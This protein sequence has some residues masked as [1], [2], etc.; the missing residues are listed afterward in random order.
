[1]LTEH[2]FLLRYFDRNENADRL[3][4]INL[5]P[6]VRYCP[7]PEPLLAPPEDR[8]WKLAWSSEEPKYGGGGTAPIQWQEE[9]WILPAHSALLF[10]AKPTNH[11]NTPGPEN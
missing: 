3:L 5:G 6:R 7:A 10:I 11:A 4:L 9:N 8:D 1:V 2:A